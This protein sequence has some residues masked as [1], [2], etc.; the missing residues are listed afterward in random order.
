MAPKIET[1][2]NDKK[3]VTIIGAGPAGLTA[4]YTLIKHGITPLVLEKTRQAGGIARTEKYKD[5]YFDIG[6]HRFFTKI[7][8][9]NRLWH[10][11]MGDE[12]LKVRRIS[13]IFYKGHFFNYPLQVS[14][15][16]HGLGIIESLLIL[17]SYIKSHLR[18]YPKVETFEHWVANRFGRRLY[19]IFFKPYTEKVWGIPC[20][21]IGAE[22]AKQR[23]KEL[24]FT[25][26]VMHAVFG[27]KTGRSMIDEFY[28]P[29]KGP[30]MMW[31]RFV[32]QLA[33]AG[34]T[35]ALNS[36][37]VCLKT[38]CDTIHS[39]VYIANGNKIEIP[40][41]HLIS[42]IPLPKLIR[43]MA[44]EPPAAVVDAAN[45]LS[46]RAFIIVLLI[47]NEEFL[48]PDQWIYI[49]SPEVKV[50]RIQNFKNWSKAM[51]PDQNLTSIGM[52]Y[53]CSE[54]DTLWLTDDHDLIQLAAREIA[55]LGLASASEITDSHVIR[56]PCAY[57]VY[58]NDYKSCLE[59]VKNHLKRFKNLQT[60]GRSGMHRYNNMDHSM[61][62]GILAVQNYLGDAHDIWSVNGDE[63]YL[64]ENRGI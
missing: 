39:A 35:T 59:T 21:Q 36:E 53:F 37:L 50:G 38:D 24:S 47:I 42:S 5:F 51:V 19:H 64:E 52:E 4:A 63:A 20:D 3:R 14:N 60:I 8:A 15:V 55:F 44:P 26:A 46:Y 18:P 11:M 43:I 45:R 25:T 30:G 12:W 33:L 32:D 57:P 48:F 40:V 31:E 34:G 58:S 28:Y 27:I 10:E 6:G 22:W 13:R 7:D 9:I 16:L 29:V 23:I 49:H 41:H 2:N 61:L 1:T 54:N 17:I 62:T 56:Q